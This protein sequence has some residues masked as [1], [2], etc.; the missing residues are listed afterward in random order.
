MTDDLTRNIIFKMSMEFQCTIVEGQEELL[1][2]LRR[3][4]EISRGGND[5]LGEQYSMMHV[6]E[7]TKTDV[8]ALFKINCASVEDEEPCIKMYRLNDSNDCILPMI[9]SE[10]ASNSQQAILIIT[11]NPNG[12]ILYHLGIGDELVPIQLPHD[13]VILVDLQAISHQ[14]YYSFS[15][16]S[17]SNLLICVGSIKK[18]HIE[19]VRL[20]DLFLAGQDKLNETFIEGS[21]VEFE[22]FNEKV[23]KELFESLQD[24]TI[25]MPIGPFDYRS[26][27]RIP[28]DVM[29][30][31]KGALLS[32][33]FKEWLSKLSGLEL[34]G[35]ASLECRHLLASSYQILNEK[36][37]EAAGLNV[38][39][40][41][42]KGDPNELRQDGGTVFYL[43]EGEQVAQI[44]PEHNKI[45]LAYQVEGCQ[46]FTAMV[47]QPID[48][49]L[50]QIHLTFKVMDE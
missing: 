39:I 30:K 23:A 44:T 42:L 43:V 7:E 13:K 3:T 48:V 22:C 35:V 28:M 15:G 24:A 1:E 8:V 29:G 33:E 41:L 31:L 16:D 38:V 21:F 32:G 17:M 12:L 6:D 25:K 20:L 18:F 46:R 4:A 9:I 19:S 11:D 37:T 5:S 10:Q 14:V 47:C 34:V 50:Y 27:D 45:S 26:Y 40:S 49:R 36:Y 2:S